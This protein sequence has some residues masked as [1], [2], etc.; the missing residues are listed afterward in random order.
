[1]ILEMKVPSPGESITEVEIATW[2]VK[3]GDYVEKDQAIAEVD[4]DK[5]TLELPAEASGIIT[6][7]AEEGDAV[8]VGQVVCLIDTSAAKPEGSAPAKEEKKEEAPKAE[9][10]KEEPKA[11]VKPAP[12]AEKTYATGTPSPAAR[13]IL[14]EKNIEAS[15][16]TGTGKGGRITKDDAVNAKASMGTPTGGNRGSERTKLSMLRRKVA[17]RLVAAKNETAMLTTFNEVNMTP[18][19]LVRN[20]YKDAFK[21]KHGGL[22]LG[23]MSFFTKAVT[24]ALQL[25]PDVNSMIDGQEKISYDFCDISVAVSGPKGLMVPV[26]R[27]AENLSFRG[28]ES[29]IKRLAIRARDGQ[30][31]VDDMTGGTFTISNGGVFGSMLSTP[32]INPPQSG[33]LGMHNIIERPIAVNGKVE[34]HPMMYVALSYDHRIIDGRESVGFLVAVKE[35]LENPVELLMDNN[36]KKALEL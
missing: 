10:K 5:A 27:N 8:A 18:I 2:L 14:D 3:D 35:G 21:A 25:Y 7:K 9:V 28:I 26:V 32:I 17:E 22:S 30:I 34:I 12:A 29:E 6:L 20:E 13:K 15:S 23:Y 1:M 11:E 31:T 36:P 24:R 16:V 19:N 33:I 4:S